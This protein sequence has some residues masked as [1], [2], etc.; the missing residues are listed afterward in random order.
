MNGSREGC[1]EQLDRD[2]KWQLLESHPGVLVHRAQNIF[3]LYC[4]FKLHST[5]VARVQYEIELHRG[6]SNTTN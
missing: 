3:E 2:K 1:R 5:V 4:T 6:Y